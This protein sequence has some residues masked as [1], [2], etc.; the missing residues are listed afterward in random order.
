MSN[1]TPDPWQGVQRQW[2]GPHGVEFDECYDADAVDRARALTDEQHQREIAQRDETIRQLHRELESERVR[3][4][5]AQEAITL[6][7]EPRC[8]TLTAALERIERH[9]D[10][11][12]E[13]D[14][15]CCANV[16]ETD[17][18]CPGC[19]AHAAIAAAPQG[20]NL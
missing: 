8:A 1:Q 10:C 3:R 20:G 12:C 6:T 2:N 19:L 11:A 7:W 14:D 9:T 15:D 17:Y 13:H 16:T 18:N 4:V 5:T